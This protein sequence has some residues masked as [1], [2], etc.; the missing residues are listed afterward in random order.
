MVRVSY[1]LESERERDS[2]GTLNNSRKLMIVICQGDQIV[3]TMN[4]SYAFYSYAH[5]YQSE[6]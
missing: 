2:P 3:S 1:W 4:M 5:G 6:H